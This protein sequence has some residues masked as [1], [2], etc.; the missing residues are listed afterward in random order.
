[1]TS[2]R[3]SLVLA[4]LLPGL[5]LAD[6]YARCAAPHVVDKYQLLRRL[7][8]DLRG[9]LPTMDEYAALDAGDSVPASTV[10]DYLATDGYRSMMRAYHEDLFWPN[11]SKVRLNNVNA[12][13]TKKVTDIAYRIAS[14]AR[15][16]LYRGNADAPCAD[17]EQVDF[18]PAFPG[19]FRPLVAAGEVDGWRMVTPYWDPTTPVKV[20]AYDAQETPTTVVSGKTLSCGYAGANSKKEC[21]CGTNLSYCYASG[22]LSSGPILSSLREQ[23]GRSVDEL[24]VPGGA[25]YTNLITSTSAWENG[26]ISFWQQNLAPNYSNTTA[27]DLQDA[28]AEN[29]SKAFTDPS[30]TKVDLK[31][32]HAG[33]LTLP[34]YLLRFQTNRGR[35]NRFRIDFRCTYFVPPDVMTPAPGCDPN[36]PDLTQ[37]CNCQYC[38]GTLEPLAAYFA[39]FSEAGT[40]NLLASP[41]PLPVHDASCVGSKSTTCARFYITD[42]TQ[43]RAGYLIPYQFADA[44]AD[45]AAHIT[46]GP[47]ALAQ[48]AIDDGSF[49]QCTV[50]RVF[51]RFVK[52]DMLVAGASTDEAGLLIQ[53]SQSF[54]D[55][56][57]SFSWLVQQVVNLPQYRSVR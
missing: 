22:G 25:P 14:A 34:A 53:L 16:N 54:K 47:R 39:N 44:H 11:V 49:A 15:T 26:P 41:N 10:P 48:S 56:N 35:A 21:G 3:I 36:A 28:T 31:G 30:W 13:L 27:Y 7:S 45:V 33:V 23:L 50:Q 46:E 42:A 38:H 40:A 37:R 57:Y 32:A 43:P 55:N 24:T 20:C 6:D 18:D 9:K 12:A 1:M 51:S 2:F 4:V 17:H 8:L 52:R 5:A 19:Q 29:P